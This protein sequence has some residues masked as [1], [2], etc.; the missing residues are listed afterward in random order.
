MIRIFLNLLVPLLVAD[1]ELGFA[2]LDWWGH[3]PAGESEDELEENQEPEEDEGEEDPDQM[4]GI[5]LPP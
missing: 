2:I 4:F 3:D 1:E 5:R